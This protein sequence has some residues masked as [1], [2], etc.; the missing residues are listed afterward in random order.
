MNEK[1]EAVTWQGR[2]YQAYRLTA[3]VLR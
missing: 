1:R 3:A 2:E